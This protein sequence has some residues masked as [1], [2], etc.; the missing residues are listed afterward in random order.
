M[1]LRDHPLMVYK[2]HRSWPPAWLW[3]AGYDTTHPR[4]EIGILKAVLRPHVQ[5]HDRCFLIMEHCGAEYVGKWSCFLPRDF[6]RTN[7]TSRQNDP[8]DWRH[9]SYLYALGCVGSGGLGLV[10]SNHRWC[11]TT[12]ARNR[13]PIWTSV[14]GRETNLP[15]EKS[16]FWKRYC[17]PES[18]RIDAY[19]ECFMK[20]RL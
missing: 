1:L 3:T 18:R 19:C 15:K 5:P 13:P 20:A 2:G 9:R 6:R 12:A 7:S 8:G 4:G 11:P 10:A 14:E 17:Y 16:E